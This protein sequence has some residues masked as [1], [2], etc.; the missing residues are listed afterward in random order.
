MDVPP[1]AASLASADDSSHATEDQ[2]SVAIPIGLKSG[3]QK[4]DEV[5]VWSKNV[6]NCPICFLHGSYI[7]WGELGFRIDRV[8]RS[9]ESK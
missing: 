4:L 3:R 7:C 1:C 9:A 8:F 6:P 5:P 2:V